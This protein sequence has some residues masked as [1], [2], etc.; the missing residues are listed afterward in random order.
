MQLNL[1]VY[2][3]LMLSSG[4][5]MGEK[6]ASEADFCGAAHVQGHLYDFG[7]WPGLALSADP[8]DRVFG[9]MWK[10]RD[11][12]SLAWLDEYEGIGPHIAIPE[13]ERIEHQAC[14]TGAGTRH[15]QVYVYRWPIDH[16]RRIF[17]G[18]WVQRELN[19]TILRPRQ[20][21]LADLQT[22]V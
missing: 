6:L 2:G 20:Q 17:S 18:R 4:H 19:S 7:K 11:T 3:T 10:L 22:A 16:S 15:A 21:P 14:V 5:P 12:A 1:F 13:Y 9:E 8:L